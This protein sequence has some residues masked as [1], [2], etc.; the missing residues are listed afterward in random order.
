MMKKES[1]FS[2]TPLAGSVLGAEEGGVRSG[3]LCESE[4]RGEVGRSVDR[5]KGQIF[6]M[7]QHIGA[8]KC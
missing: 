7:R 4:L 2:T 6:H 8:K 3:Q 5:R 1:P